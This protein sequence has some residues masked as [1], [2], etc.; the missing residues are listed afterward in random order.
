MSALGTTAE[1]DRAIVLALDNRPLDGA[2][3]T[4][5]L[6]AAASGAAS[7]AAPGTGTAT[8]N[9]AF[10]RLLAGARAVRR[11]NFNT[12]LHL[13]AIV[14][15]KSGGCT[16]DCAFCAQSGH[17]KTANP[18]HAFLDPGQ[19]E[20]AALA[21][22]ARGASRF[23]IVTS[24]LALNADDFARLLLAVR[25]V[26]GTGLYADVSVGLLGAERLA[27]LVD[28]GLSGVH[29]NLETARSFFP[30]ICT[31]HS[32]DEDV[33]AVRLALAAGLFVCCGGIFGLG[34]SWD[35]RAELGQTLL[36]LGVANVPVNF[37]VPIPG[38][39][40]EHRPVLSQAEALGILALLRLMLP[41]ANLR[42]CGGR[43]AVFGSAAPAPEGEGMRELF[44]SGISGL[45]IGDYLTLKGSPAE[46]DLALARELGLTPTPT[47]NPGQ[48]R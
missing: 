2:A 35:E 25:L 7:G 27:W 40:L 19:I 12:D 48:G 39:R 16:E 9:E 3:L 8:P 37:L 22:R 15:A 21:A 36:E 23:G 20:Q 26:R 14:N 44:R 46:A 4:A 31:T 11:R 33:E 5:V 41:R 32:Y 6:S 17:H 1:L 13:C 43:S 38:T 30:Q 29:H 28:A 10:G 18:R 47:P 24:G 45:M 34:E 42:V